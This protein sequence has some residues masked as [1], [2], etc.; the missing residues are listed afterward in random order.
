MTTNCV[1]S[2][3]DFAL[4][5]FV[6]IFVPH[7]LLD[8]FLM[9]CSLLVVLSSL[10]DFKKSLADFFAFEFN[11]LHGLLPLRNLPCS[12]FHG[13]RV[14]SILAACPSCLDYVLTFWQRWQFVLDILEVGLRPHSI[15]LMY[16]CHVYNTWRTASLSLFAQH[17]RISYLYIYLTKF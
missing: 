17:G 12:F 11:L 10:C 1:A 5:S 16:F 7:F 3:S 8:S 2:S 14:K 4:L 13:I 9:S 15:F 6:L